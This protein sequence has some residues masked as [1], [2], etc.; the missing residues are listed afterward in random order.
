[1]RKFFSYGPI[2]T[3]LHFYAPRSALIEQ[4]LS[5][6]VGEPAAGYGHYITV[7]APRQ[8]GKTWI[9]QQVQQ[10]LRQNPIYQER[11]IVAKLNLEY[12]KFTTDVDRVAQLIANDLIRDLQLVHPGIATFDELPTLFEQKI[13]K[14]PL[15]LILDEFD[16]LSE[17]TINRVAAVL[18]NI[19]IRQRDEM[20]RPL[21]ERSYLL[22][23]VALIGVRSVLGIE[24]Q[25]GSP[26]NVQHSLHIP[27][28]TSTEVNEMFQWYSSESGQKIEQEVIDRIYVETNGQPGL[29][30][31][32]GELITETFNQQPDQPIDMPLFEKAYAAAIDLLPN[33]NIL[34]IISKV[35]EEPYR[36][37]VLDLFKTSEKSAFRYDDPQLNFLYMNGVI[38]WEKSEPI[39]HVTK[40]ACPLIQKRLF[41]YFAYELS[42]IDGDIYDPFDN[43]T[44]V[45]A[46]DGL[47]V[48]NLLRRYEQYF[49]KNQSW[50]L[51]D[52][53]LRSDL[54]PYEAIYHFNLYTYLVK[55][56]QRRNGQVIP[57][58]PT[59]NG[60]I[61]LLLKYNDRIYALELKSYV[62]AYAYRNAL[63]QALRYA[64]QMQLQTM[65]LVFFVQ[66]INDENRQRYESAF[67]DHNS[68]I[69]IQPVFIATSL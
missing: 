50:I 25:S 18:R 5:E 41:N 59:G 56:L 30:G 52:V 66:N 47:R 55:F 32:L 22:H 61:D 48:V 2:D 9:L 26:F 23:G 6:L 16:A 68:G 36:Q 34:N 62:D 4:A 29:V 11:F 69:L 44:D 67:V 33:S 10:R 46:E 38:T 14:K 35:K 65:W 21:A 19:Y 64:E 58:F 1:M 60:Q 51:K 53:P 57:E 63:Q 39:A 43:L 54:R 31:W 42:P 3:R 7:W 27:N 8:S 40:F 17:A 24:N 28:L 12:L 13:L 15:I 49:R 37:T 45:F 20:D